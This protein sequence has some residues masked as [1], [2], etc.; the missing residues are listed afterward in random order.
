VAVICNKYFSSFSVITGDEV[1]KIF[2]IYCGTSSFVSEFNC[3]PLVTFLNLMALGGTLPEHFMIPFIMIPLKVLY[4]NTIR[5][6]LTTPST[7]A[8]FISSHPAVVIGQKCDTEYV[9]KLQPCL[10][11]LL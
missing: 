11:G 6:V 4:D 9:K 10:A 1:V 3:P 7:R 5:S 8:H 2:S